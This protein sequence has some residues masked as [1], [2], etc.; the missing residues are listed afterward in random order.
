[1]FNHK[2]FGMKHE[3]MVLRFFALIWEREKNFKCVN[4]YLYFENK[5]NIE[6]KS[7]SPKHINAYASACARARVCVYSTRKTRK[8]WPYKLLA[9]KN[10]Q[11]MNSVFIVKTLP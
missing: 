1:M 2:S 3:Q 6:E 8:F 11:V 4:I 10:K 5:K 9:I 7:S